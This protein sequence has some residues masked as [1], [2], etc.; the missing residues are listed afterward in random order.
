M[1]PRSLARW[2]ATLGVVALLIAGGSICR[3]CARD[4]L[5]RLL[6]GLCRAGPGV[7]A[8]ERPPPDHDARPIDGRLSG[9]DSHPPRA[10]R[11]RGCRDPGWRSRRRARQA[12]IGARRQQGRS[13]P[14]AD[15]H[16]G[17]RRG[18]E[19]GHRQRRGVPEHA[20]CGEVHRATRTAAAAPIYRPRCSRSSASR[21]RWRARA[22]RY[23]GRRPASRWP[24]SSRVARRRSA[25]SR[26]ASSY[27][28]LE[29]PSSARFRPSSSQDFL[30]PVRSPA[31]A[32]QP[33]A[34]GALIR[35]LASPE[36]APAILKAGLM[37]LSER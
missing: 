29:L 34:A 9:G 20:A 33:D 28:S 16:G 32:R 35:F 11:D 14:L 24:R 26:S 10:R 6:W 23:A 12:R 3:R 21:T 13:R 4:D 2:L 17:A 8:R 22:E 36:A 37:P 18:R 7:R 5:G 31:T 19:A 25:F 15:R 27:T 1:K 30:S